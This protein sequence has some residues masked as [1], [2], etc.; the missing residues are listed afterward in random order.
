M[1]LQDKHSPIDRDIV[2]ALIAATPESWNS[3]NLYV[4]REEDSNYSEKMVVEISSPEGHT[5]MISATDAIYENL[6]RLSDCFRNE[7][8][9]WS[10]VKYEIALSSGGDWKYK[11]DFSY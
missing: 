6:Y 3:A 1:T 9:N 7:G 5:D 2:N 10:E 4:K 11:V 8:K